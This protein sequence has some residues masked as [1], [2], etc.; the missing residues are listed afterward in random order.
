MRFIGT[1]PMAEILRHA[2]IELYVYI[3]GG[4]C[5]IALPRSQTQPVCKLSTFETGYSYRF[6]TI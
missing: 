4:V 3:C 2:Y 1:G 6:L 5:R